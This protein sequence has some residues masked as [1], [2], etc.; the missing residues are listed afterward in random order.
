METLVN[1]TSGWAAGLMLAVLA[2]NK[3]QDRQRFLESFNGAHIFLREYFM[4]RRV[5]PADRRGKNLLAKNLHSEAANR[6]PV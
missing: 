5:T 3:Q 1:R 2:L 4:E 6:Q